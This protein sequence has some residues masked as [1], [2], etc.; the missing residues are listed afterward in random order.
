MTRFTLSLLLLSFLPCRVVADPIYSETGVYIKYVETR[1]DG[2]G[3]RRIDFYATD[4]KSRNEY[5][6]HAATNG[7]DWVM[8]NPQ[9]VVDGRNPEFGP[10]KPVEIGPA[11]QDVSRRIATELSIQLERFKKFKAGAEKFEGPPQTG[12][13][14]SPAPSPRNDEGSVQFP[15][16]P[17]AG[18]TRGGDSSY[19]RQR[20]AEL[21]YRVGETLNQMN[22]NLRGYNDQRSAQNEINSNIQRAINGDLEARMRAHGEKNAAIKAKMLVTLFNY[23][24][25]SSEENSGASIDR[26]VLTDIQLTEEGRKQVQQDLRDQI[27]KR[28]WMKVADSITLLANPWSGDPRDPALKD[29]ADQSGIMNGKVLKPNSFD[30]QGRPTVQH[31]I[32]QAANRLQAFVEADQYWSTSILMKSLIVDVG[33]ALKTSSIAEKWGVRDKAE[34]LLYFAESGIDFMIGVD[35]GFMVGAIRSGAGF[36]ELAVTVTEAVGNTALHP[37]RTGQA[38]LDV[39]K[40][41]VSATELLADPEVWKDIHTALYTTITETAPAMASEVWAHVSQ[42]AV[43]GTAKERGNLIGRTQFEI[44]SLI[45]PDPFHHIFLKGSKL[46][47]G[48]RAVEEFAEFNRVLDR[49]DKVAV[50]SQRYSKIAATERFVGTL[51]ELSELARLDP[52]KYQSFF[53]AFHGHVFRGELKP[54]EILYQVQRKDQTSAGSWFLAI[55]PGDAQSAEALANIAKWYN[56]G[57]AVSTYVVK[58]R[59]SVYAGAVAGGEGHQIFIPSLNTIRDVRGVDLPKDIDQIVEKVEEMR[60]PWRNP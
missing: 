41:M 47:A 23:T 33:A 21:S 49:L 26:G 54:G 28:Q 11:P 2:Q 5:V 29:I 12:P 50:A 25:R 4:M 53:D 15:I 52:V 51:P 27:H 10:R 14:L 43:N 56:D 8:T 30:L 7:R 9:Q 1:S 57:H 37:I 24:Q 16:D 34:T 46:F 18:P 20:I 22:W 6:V 32:R 35:S 44:V 60:L 55:K 13:G 58:D 59:I 42:I 3:N 48:A 17:G 31:R 40:N 36:A 38:A 45:F 39:A 19:D